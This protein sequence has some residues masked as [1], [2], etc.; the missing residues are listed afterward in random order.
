MQG[1]S[2]V[3]RSFRIGIVVT[4]LLLAAGPIFG[5]DTKAPVPDSVSVRALPVEGS[6]TAGETRSEALLQAQL[7]AQQIEI[8]LLKDRVKG[9]EAIVGSLKSGKRDQNAGV[10]PEVP[11]TATY[12]TAEYRTAEYAAVETPLPAQP[13]TPPAPPAPVNHSPYEPPRELLPDIGQVGAEFG[14]LTGGSTNPFNADNGAFFGGFIDLPFKKIPVRGGKLSY[15]IMITLQRNVTSNI[16]VTSGI[17]ALVNNAL[18]GALSGSGPGGTCPLPITVNTQQR[19][20]VLTVVPISLKYTFTKFDVHRFRPY[21]VVGL[22]NYVTITSQNTTGGIGTTNPLL[23]SLLNGPLIGGLA[24]EAPQLR[25]LGVPNGQGDF[26]F[27]VSTGG[28]FEY[29]VFPKLS[30]G[31]EYRANKMEGKNGFFSSF[32][33][34]TAFHF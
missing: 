21:A 29:R 4:S 3:R 20:T 10:A 13:S 7:R 2:C 1:D 9:L 5:Q 23:N 12:K 11:A 30:L 18:C 22:G 8:E 34:R 26:R 15:E 27:G 32:A 24:P 31:F 16:P 33:G 14:L 19:M 25:A 28:G 17:F 6:E